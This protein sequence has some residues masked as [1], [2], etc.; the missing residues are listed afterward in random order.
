[1]FIHYMQSVTTNHCAHD[2]IASLSCNNIIIKTERTKIVSNK[3][4]NI[5]M[6]RESCENK[7]IIV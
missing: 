4:N 2:Y 7:F 6:N 3:W 5:Y 1:M